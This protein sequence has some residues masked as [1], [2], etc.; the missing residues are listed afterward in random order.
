MH[1]WKRL[2]RE[3]TGQDTVE[4]ALLAALISIVAVTAL[5]NISPLVRQ[6]FAGIRFAMMNM[7]SSG[8]F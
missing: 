5:Y 2:L 6:A 4:W 8:W 1:L 3:T 7:Q